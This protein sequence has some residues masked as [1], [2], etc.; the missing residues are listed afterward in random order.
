V[1][2]ETIKAKVR[3]GNW[4]VSTHADQEAADENIGI[5]EIRDA[6]LGDELL[7]QYADT[8]RGPSCLLLGFVKGRPIHVVCGWRGAAAVII[9]VY[10]PKPPKFEDPRTRRRSP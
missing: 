6:I 2:I 4:V 9:T 10:V 3:S 8:G 7:E 5:A 1:D